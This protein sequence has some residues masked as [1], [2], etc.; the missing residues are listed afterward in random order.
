MERV[1]SITV[2][3]CIL[4]GI[5]AEDVKAIQLHGFADASKVAYGAN[6]YIWLTTSNA[7]SSH[8]LASKTRVAPLKEETIPRLELMAALTLAN[9]ITS[10]YEALNCTLKID[11]V[12]NWIDSQI[13]WWCING[14]SKQF[15]QFVQNRVQK[16]RSLWSKEHWRYCP[17]ELNPSDI[18]SRGA[19]GSDI[20]S[21]DLWWKGAPFVEKEEDQWPSLPNCPISESTVSDGATKEL[22]K[23]I[24]SVVTASVQVSQNIS[25]VIQPDKFSSLNKL[26][27]VT[28]LV[29]KFI[30]RIKRSTETH[31][32]ISAQE[33][34]ASKTLWL[35]EVQTKFEEKEKS[36]SI[37]EQLGVFKDEAGVLRCKGRIQNSSVPYSV[38]F[39]ILLPRK[40]HFT[41]LVILQ[42]QWS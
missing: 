21:S 42:S 3:R 6:V 35:K 30:K 31:P 16:I 28:A 23:E 10:V 17:S 22:R 29:L 11:G 19:K 24:S 7:H 32:D 26:I 36:S 1:S 20:A 38:K 18:A 12:F 33:M 15:K 39:P 5:E 2:P 34:N 40:Q 37:W 27:R 41:R 4:N 8:L 14:E 9:L 25:E 13:V